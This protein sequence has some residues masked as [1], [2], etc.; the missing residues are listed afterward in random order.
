MVREDFDRQMGRDLFMES[1]ESAI[2]W[3]VFGI[4]IA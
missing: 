4:P 2:E 3:R 1:D